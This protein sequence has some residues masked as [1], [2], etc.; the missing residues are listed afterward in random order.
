MA[1]RIMVDV[2]MATNHKIFTYSCE[3]P[4]KVCKVIQGGRINYQL[5]QA[6]TAGTWGCGGSHKAFKRL[7]GERMNYFAGDSV[8]T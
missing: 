2:E 8:F 4:N 6:I 1:F 5:T 7:I 3:E